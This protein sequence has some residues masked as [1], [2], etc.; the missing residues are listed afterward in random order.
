[1]HSMIFIAQ[2]YY[3]HEVEIVNY[4]ELFRNS[5]SRTKRNYPDSPGRSWRSEMDIEQY[6][7]NVVGHKTI[8]ST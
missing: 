3:D 2:F 1:M 4:R 8:V 6:Q 5:I 7:D